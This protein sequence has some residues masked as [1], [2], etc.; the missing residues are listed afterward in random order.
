MAAEQERFT[1]SLQEN[2]IT[3]LAYNDIEGRVLS[4]TLNTN[5]LDPDFRTIADECI[6]YWQKYDKAPLDHTADLVGHIIDDPNNR[7]AKA[8]TRLLKG[9]VG[10]SSSMNTAYILTQQ[11]QHERSQ[12]I[13][14]AIIESAEKIN[15]QQHL[16]IGEIEDIWHDLLAE[17]K[18][19]NFDPGLRL[20]NYRAVLD[21]LKLS[22]SEFSSGVS[23]LDRKFI[24]PSRGELFIWLGPSG[25]GKT[26]AL[27]M[28]GA[29]ALKK[30]KKVL[31]I[32]LEVSSH[33]TAQRYY[34]YLF[35]CSKRDIPAETT[36]LIIRNGKL[37]GMRP[38]SLKTAFALD[39]ES[40]A[41]DELRSHIKIFGKRFDNLIIK[42][43]PPGTL[44]L[45]D[46]DAYLDALEQE[47]F[48][49]D[50]VV[51]DYAGIMETDVKNTRDSH[52]SNVLG[53]RTQA[54]KRNQAWVTAWQ[55]N[56][57]GAEAKMVKATHVA[58]AWQVI[59]HGDNIVSF[60][61]SDR[62]FLLGL[63]RGFVA[64]GRGD[65]DKFG[66]LMTQSFAVGQF[67]IDSHWL[68]SAYFKAL[69]ELPQPDGADDDEA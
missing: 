12:Q 29:E 31:H 44:S 35:H 33:R 36:D 10:L 17:N 46:L 25:R 16:A 45:K 2:L 32:T 56:R 40:L 69:E 34:Q 57:A 5:L 13:R 61:S 64:K 47:G 20:S 68:N 28:Q 18:V 23:I 65:Q 48:I 24:Q 51:T 50:L 54:V 9:M 26:W 67:C 53:L 60:S 4:K 49:P 8:I 3:V 15:S 22:D 55:S 11:R 27:V 38:R 39:N 43:F 30:Q 41:A 66:F 7:R 62:E 63:C 21:A 42:S 59:Q 58:E 6:A 14:A 1:H 19:T 52:S 37:E